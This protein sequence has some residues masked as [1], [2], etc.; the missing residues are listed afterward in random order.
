[1]RYIPHSPEEQAALLAAIGVSSMD[2]LFATVPQ[3]GLPP[4]AA[5]PAAARLRDRGAPG[6]GADRRAEREPLGVDVVP[7][8]GPLLPPHAGLRLAAPLAGRVP[9]RVHAVP[10]RGLAGDA[11]GDLGVPDAHGPPHRA[12]RRE[13]LDVRG[14]LGL[15]RGRPD[16]RA[17]HEE[18]DEGRRLEGDPPRV[19]ALPP[20]VPRELPLHDRRGARRRGR[21]DGPGGSRGGRGRRRPSPSP[22]SLRTSSASSKAGRP[23]PRRR[24]RRARSRSAS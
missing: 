4:G 1:M 17:P 9:D 21:R 18:E 23:P 2:D 5:G 11:H 8:R 16:G 6:D 20:D 10:A 15:R 13:R 3:R 7:R 12:G 19:P 22:S 14:G 24:T